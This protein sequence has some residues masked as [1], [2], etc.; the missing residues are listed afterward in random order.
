MSQIALSSGSL[1]ARMARPV[2]SSSCLLGCTMFA[3]DLLGQCISSHTTTIDFKRSLAVGVSGFFVSG[4]LTFCTSRLVH[5]LYPGYGRLTVLKRTIV[6]TCLSP[7]TIACGIVPSVYLQTRNKQRVH[8]KL[9]NRVPMNWAMSMLLLTPFSYIHSRFIVRRFQ[10]LTRNSY[11]VVYNSVVSCKGNS[12]VE[13][14][15][16]LEMMF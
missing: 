4:P 3:G 11:N 2:L 14:D 15:F 10:N 9:V 6:S 5:K 7:L 12:H 1:I 8:E 13:D 16:L